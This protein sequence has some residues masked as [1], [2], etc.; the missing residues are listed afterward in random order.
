MDN[1]ENM[2]LT[3]AAAHK[4]NG[5]GGEVWISVIVPMYNVSPHIQR[6]LD[7]IRTQS[8][9]KALE[10]IIVDDCSTDGAPELVNRAA[11]G[12]PRIRL[13]C[14]PA[15]AGPAAARNAGLD[16]A[17][18]KYIFFMD[19][20]DTMEPDTL[21]LLSS[22]A[23]EA[24]YDLVVGDR[25]R[26]LDGRNIEPEK[27]LFDSDRV[28]NREDVKD[29]IEKQ[30]KLHVSV[31]TFFGPVW[32]RLYKRSV[33]V[34]NGVRFD[35][36][37]RFYEDMAFNYCFAGYVQSIRYVRKQLYAYHIY[38]GAPTAITAN[39]SPVSCKK[40]IPHAYRSL[41]LHG[42]SER[43]ALVITRH[44]MISLAVKSLTVFY[45]TFLRGKFPPSMTSRSLLD[46]VVQIVDDKDI[47]ISL[48]SYRPDAGESFWI[49][50]FMRW[51]CY[52]LVGLASKMRAGRII[53][54]K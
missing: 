19:A 13:Q 4:G 8:L 35:E 27:Y 29:I 18:G 47:R 38:P 21:A 50:F 39:N 54:G 45:I 16:M 25:M 40:V 9:G 37:L 48:A 6:C 30:L 2:H 34:E 52:R 46:Y 20:D 41:L 10:I 33:I 15:N 24:D 53:G 42:A 36:T 17:R 28:F 11:E 31:G 1:A 51:R 5:G 44:G 7:A 32:G 26:M 43:E 23:E 49:P 22:A 3:P 12:D 14:L